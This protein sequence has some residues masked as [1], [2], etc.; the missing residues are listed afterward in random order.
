LESLR[1]IA[2]LPEATQSAHL[3]RLFVI[4][5]PQSAHV[6]SGCLLG[7]VALFAVAAQLRLQNLGFDVSFPQTVQEDIFGSS[8]P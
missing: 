8:R 5:A 7:E 2:R 4:A 6:P 3:L 1:A